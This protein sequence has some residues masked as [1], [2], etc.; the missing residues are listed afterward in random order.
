MITRLDNTR[1]VRAPR[2]TER[3]AKSWLTEA[4]LRMLMN[5]LD[6]E[7]AERPGELVVY[8]GIGRAVRDWQSFD[9]IVAA[10]RDLIKQRRILEV[11]VAR[12]KR[13][14]AVEDASRYRDALGTPIPQGVADRYLQPVAD[15]IGDLV[16]AVVVEIGED[17]HAELPLRHH[18][19]HRAHRQDLAGVKRR[20]QSLLG[21]QEPAEAVLQVVRIL[22]TEN[23]KRGDR[24]IPRVDR[25]EIAAFNGNMVFPPEAGR[26]VEGLLAFFSS[27]RIITEEAGGS[28]ER[29]AQTHFFLDAAR[30][31]RGVVAFNA[32]RDI[33]AARRLMDKGLAMNAA[34]LADP[35]KGWQ[36][37]AA[38]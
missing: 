8:G 23:L 11:T 31:L 34:A 38:P 7:V 30:R 32:A 37:W 36:Q 33:G 16:L 2:G 24:L 27:F 3:S 26:K 9:R 28:G 17:G 15:P 6:P 21:A 13:F 1:T 5:N 10:L 4:P 35:G 14:I 22:L 20:L 25:L 18:H 12:D 29:G 19:E